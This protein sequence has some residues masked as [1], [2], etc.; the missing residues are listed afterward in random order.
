MAVVAIL[1]LA[2]CGENSQ[3][4]STLDHEAEMKARLGTANHLMFAG[5]LDQALTKLETLHRDF[6]HDTEVIEA[7]GF[8]YTKKQ[9]YALAGFYFDHALKSDPTRTDIALY[10]GKAHLQAENWHFAANAYATYLQDHPNDFD[11]WKALAQANHKLGK[12]K[13]TLDAY[14]NAFSNPNNKPNAQEGNRIGTLFLRLKNHTQATEWF[15]YALA[16]TPPKPENQSQALLGLLEVAWQEENWHRA[17]ELIDELDELAPQALEQ[18]SLAYMRKAI[19]AFNDAQTVLKQQRILSALETNSTTETTQSKPKPSPIDTSSHET[20]LQSD[21]SAQ[22]ATLTQASTPAHAPT[23][24][25]TAVDH[26]TP[27]LE[28]SQEPET[29]SQEKISTQNIS[30]LSNKSNKYPP[31][32]PSTETNLALASNSLDT[33]EPESSNPLLDGRITIDR[34]NEKPTAAPEP[35]PISR[36]ETAK[37]FQQSGDYSMAISQFQAFLVDN[38]TSGEACFELSNTY[39]LTNNWSA[40]ELYA[41]EAIR[42]DPDNLAYTLNYLKTVQKNQH[43][44]RLVKE[45][46]RAKEKFPHSPDITLALAQ[47]Y[48]HII[49]NPRNA[50]LLYQEYLDLAPLEHPNR[51]KAELALNKIVN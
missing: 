25:T 13:P 51:A 34:L 46:V 33:V 3:N 44:E 38:P 4:R 29:E 11:A 7:L 18:S 27:E 19:K 36:L 15:E 12:I 43:Q 5:Q 9:D 2:A 40:A 20:D 28:S 17:Q 35:K 24:T 37:T 41:S 21:S 47:A 16:F 26:A 32:P 49:K 42:L 10:S 31:A 39:F 50:S 30:G 1:F 48:D 22:N 45:L 6:P 14:L 23:T 8:A